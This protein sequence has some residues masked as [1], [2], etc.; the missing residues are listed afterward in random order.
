VR[1]LHVRRWLGAIL[2]AALPALAAAGDAR[3]IVQFR[4]GRARAGRDALRAAGGRVVLALEAQE[5][6][7]ARL[8]P[9]ALARLRRN[10]NVEHVERDPLRFPQDLWSDSLD[11]ETLPY[12]IQ[13]VQADLVTG[14]EAA[15]RTVCIVDS[16]YSQQH[17]DLKDAAAGEVA[18]DADIG[19]GAWDHDTCGHGT[20]VAGTAAATAGNGLGVVGANP[21]VRLHIVKVFGD[22]DPAGASCAW[23]YS[24]NLVAA[25]SRCLAAGAHVVNMSLG[26][27][28]VARTERRAFRRFH[29]KGVLL[30]A[31][32]GN[33]FGT[34]RYFP[35]AYPGVVSVT[36]LDANEGVASFAQKNADVELAAAGHQVLSTWPRAGGAPGSGYQARSGTSMAAAHVSAVAALLWSCHPSLASEAVR[37]ALAATARDLGEPGRDPAYGFGLVQAREALAF[38]GPSPACTVR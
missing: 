14:L 2:A 25:V 13:M 34:E 33:G 11:G 22:D 24:S 17:E 29:R 21:G 23:T 5:A 9:R 15:N 20:H 16:G 6:V 12:G 30:V 18:F 4:A 7:A 36:A 32:A 26:G 35:A 28:E 31:S 38:L 1:A 3:Y 37:G 10:G 19:S 27:P 8:S